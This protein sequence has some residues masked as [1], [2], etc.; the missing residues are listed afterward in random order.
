[1][2][3]PRLVFCV[4]CLSAHLAPIPVVALDVPISGFPSPRYHARLIA[5]PPRTRRPRCLGPTTV[6]SRAPDPTLARLGRRQCLGTD[7]PWPPSSRPPGWPTAASLSRRTGAASSCRGCRARTRGRSARHCRPY[8]CSCRL[9]R[10]R[11]Q[12]FRYRGLHG[13][14][15]DRQP[16]RPCPLCPS[17]P[18]LHRIRKAFSYRG[19]RGWREDRWAA[20]RCRRC[21]SNRHLHRVSNSAFSCREYRERRT[22]RRLAHLYPLYPTNCRLGRVPHSETPLLSA[23]SRYADDRCRIHRP[24]ALQQRVHQRARQRVLQPM[25]RR[26]PALSLRRDRPWT[27]SLPKSEA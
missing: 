3:A 4:S 16:A 8:P 19:H 23:A 10:V 6:A 21:P 18:Q 27:I 7:F 20:R 9:R 24:F 22:G 1:M 14:R 17:N 12:A 15:W 2:P 11:R 13:G 5:T 25:R 26:G